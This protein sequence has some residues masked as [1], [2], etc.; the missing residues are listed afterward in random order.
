MEDQIDFPSKW[1]VEAESCARDDFLHFKW[2]SS[3]H[4]EFL[5]SIHVEVSHFKPDYISYFP[6]HEL[7][8]CLFLHF[9]LSHFVDS[10]G[11]I[12]GSR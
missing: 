1:D 10:F 8:G 9:L 6:G 7:G 3:F 11:I 4:F 2:S 5:G 12:L